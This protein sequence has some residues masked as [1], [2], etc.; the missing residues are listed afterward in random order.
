MEEGMNLSIV[1]SSATLISILTLVYRVWRS[2]KAQKIEQPIQ[3]TPSLCERQIK[4]NSSDHENI[5]ARLGASEQ[6]ISTLEAHNEHTNKS[7][8]R[9]EGKLDK[10]IRRDP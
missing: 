6:R 4:S 5:F 7:L 3:V 8:D 2:G 1:L 9:I 10:L